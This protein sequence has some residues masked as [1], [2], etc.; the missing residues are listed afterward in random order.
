MKV[1]NIADRKPQD[2][3]KCKKQQNAGRREVHDA[4]ESKMPQTA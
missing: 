1:S 2:V 4:A 3:E